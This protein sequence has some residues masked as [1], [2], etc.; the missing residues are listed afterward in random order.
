MI[1]VA[2]GITPGS[3]PGH[4]ALFGYDPKNEIH[5]LKDKQSQR[6]QAI[7]TEADKFKGQERTEFVKTKM[8]ALQQD[9]L[10]KRNA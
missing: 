6:A 5:V 1:P 4:L 2:P 7:I 9:V 10:A 8:E 3:G